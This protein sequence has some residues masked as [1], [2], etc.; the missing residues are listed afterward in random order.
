MQYCFSLSDF[1]FCTDDA[2]LACFKL[3]FS[4]LEFGFSL[5]LEEVTRVGGLVQLSIFALS[6]KP[7]DLS[8]SQLEVVKFELSFGKVELGNCT[9]RFNFLVSSIGQSEPFRSEVT[10][11]CR[12]LDLS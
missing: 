5:N 11:G 12:N 2:A 9:A 6:L 1:G 8:N 7:F 3:I 10:F 4:P